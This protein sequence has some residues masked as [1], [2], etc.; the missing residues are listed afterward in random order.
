LHSPKREEEEKEEKEERAT[1]VAVE[2]NRQTV[3]HE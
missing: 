2:L 3:R 1:A